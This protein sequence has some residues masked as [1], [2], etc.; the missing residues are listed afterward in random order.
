[1]K[2]FWVRCRSFSPEHYKMS[3]APTRQQRA[4][5]T[6]RYCLLHT[7]HAAMHDMGLNDYRVSEKIG[8]WEVDLKW[9]YTTKRMRFPEKLGG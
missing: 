9:C 2:R 3:G 6:L 8:K 7:W 1:M 4:I 5:T